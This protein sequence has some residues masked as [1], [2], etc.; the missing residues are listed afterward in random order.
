MFG[1]QIR[2]SSFVA[3]G[4]RN[5]E[6]RTEQ[7]TPNTNREP[8]SVNGP[9]PSCRLASGI[10]DRR[11]AEN[12]LTPLV[13]GLAHPARHGVQAPTPPPG[14]CKSPCD[15]CQHPVPTSGHVPSLEQT[16]NSKL[17]NEPGLQLFESGVWRLEFLVIQDQGQTAARRAQPG[18]RAE[19]GRCDEVIRAGGT[20][21]AHSGCGDRR[22]PS[23]APLRA[24]THPRGGETACAQ[25][26]PID[27]S[28]RCSRSA[29]RPSRRTGRPAGC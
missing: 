28:F 13:A 12:R 15:S 26:R 7:R 16:S 3:A 11:V 1:V 4:T 24:A 21:S 22:S 27:E 20:R 10:Y 25:P 9:F 17:T 18:G 29:A 2:S 6:R 5:P 19:D 23:A 8:S 14:R